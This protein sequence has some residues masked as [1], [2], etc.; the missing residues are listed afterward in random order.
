[1]EMCPE[2]L[3]THAYFSGVRPPRHRSPLPSRFTQGAKSAA[4]AAF[5]QGARG[6][7]ATKR[8]LAAV[9]VLHLAPA[10]LGAYRTPG[11][12]ASAA[13]APPR[14]R[15]RRNPSGLSTAGPAIPPGPKQGRRRRRSAFQ[16]GSGGLRRHRHRG[17][18]RSPAPPGFLRI[19]WPRFR[20][21]ARRHAGRRHARGSNGDAPDGR[22]AACTGP[23]HAT[24]AAADPGGTGTP[25][26][27]ALRAST[28]ATAPLASHALDPNEAMQ[29]PERYE[30]RDQVRK[31][32]VSR[33]G[34]QHD[35]M[36]PD[37]DRD[38]AQ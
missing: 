17:G 7:R 27:T 19:R 30:Y 29:P 22:H 1:M 8:L 23:R 10:E 5:A 25:A 38:N 14:R 3:K 24:H 4:A 31:L 11:P 13:R 28:L 12:A 37:S 16:R 15:R 34:L 18:T 9:S 20:R 21:H 26:R 6:T 36:F 35:D 32:F 2:V 33:N